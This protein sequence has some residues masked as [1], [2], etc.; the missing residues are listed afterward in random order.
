M[1]KIGCLVF[2]PYE[3]TCFRECNENRQRQLVIEGEVDR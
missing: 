3:E 2:L 1:T